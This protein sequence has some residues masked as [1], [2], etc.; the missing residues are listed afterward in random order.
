MFTFP[1]AERLSSKKVIGRL[2]K[3]GSAEVTSYYLFPFRVMAITEPV[4]VLVPTPAAETNTESVAAAFP[5]I[6]ISVSKKNFKR[7]VDRNLIRRR[8]REAYRLNKALIFS[9]SPRTLPTY[10]A[11]LYTAKTILSFEEIEKGTKL[12]LRKL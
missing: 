9:S 8:I 4:V 2:F 5:A 6:L 12:A 10:I 1:K 3:R 7:A 11:F